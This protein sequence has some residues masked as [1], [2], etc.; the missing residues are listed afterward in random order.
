M[1]CTNFILK[2]LPKIEGSKTTYRLSAYIPF[3]SIRHIICFIPLE[4]KGFMARVPAKF[5]NN[6]NMKQTNNI[7]AALITPASAAPE[8]SQPQVTKLFQTNF[9]G[10]KN[11]VMP[12]CS[13]DHILSL[14]YGCLS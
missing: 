2:A 8:K 5:R 7:G 4:S 3:E 9:A 10:I 1:I 14:L 6:T 11:K 13:E 12:Q